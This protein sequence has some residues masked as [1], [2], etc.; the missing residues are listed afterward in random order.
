M[1]K[2]RTLVIDDDKSLLQTLTLMLKRLDHVPIPYRY[3]DTEDIEQIKENPPDLML[4]DQLIRVEG[5]PGILG[6]DIAKRFQEDPRTRYTPKVII[7][8]ASKEQQAEIAKE[9]LRSGLLKEV[10]GKKS[11]IFKLIEEQY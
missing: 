7:T 9:A 11:D 6:V 8:G 10:I 3:V 5:K 2:P 4:L 1:R